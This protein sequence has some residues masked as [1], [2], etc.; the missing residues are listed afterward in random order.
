[1]C[2]VSVPSLQKRRRKIVLKRQYKI[3]GE[4]IVF[5]A[6]TKSLPYVKELFNKYGRENIN[7][8]FIFCSCYNNYGDKHD[9]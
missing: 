1:M 3:E 5:M 8:K 7:I 4:N 9:R 2:D 6:Y